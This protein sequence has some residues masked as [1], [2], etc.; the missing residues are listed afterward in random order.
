MVRKLLLFTILFLLLIVVLGGCSEANAPSQ[1]TESTV[2]PIE[3]VGIPPT[4]T[5]EVNVTVSPTEVPDFPCD[6][7][8]QSDR[9]GN[10]EIYVMA[11]DGS[12]Q[13][14]LSQNPGDDFDPVWSPDGT[15]IAFVSNR[16]NGG[17]GGLFVYTMRADGSDVTQVSHMNESR[18]P[19]WSPAGN[20]IVYSSQGDIYV[21]DVI[22]GEEKN[23][24]NSPE[25]DEQPKISPSGRQIAWLIGSESD[26]QLNVMDMDGTNRLKVTHAGKVFD[27]EW[28]VDGRIFTHWEQPEGICNNCLVT[29]DGSQVSD[30]GGKGTIQEFRPFWTADGDRVELISGD[31]HGTG[32]EDV[33]LVGDIFPDIFY[34]LTNS[35]GNDR[36]PD[37][38]RMC[39]PTHG[40]YPQ[41]GADPEEKTVN[42]PVDIGSLVIGYTG[43]IGAIEQNDIDQA[44]AELELE[45]VKGENITEL[46]DKGVDAI[47]IASNR[48]DITGSYPAIHDAAER[49]IPLFILNA[50][51]NEPGVINLSAEHEIY[52]S[53]FNW[54]FQQMNGEGKFIYYNF[55]DNEY[56]QN[57]VDSALVHYPEIIGVKMA[58]DYNGNSFTQQDI[59]GMIISDPELDAVW[60]TEKMNDIFWG[61]ND[62]AAPRRLPAECMARKDELISWKILMDSGSDFQCITHIRPGGTAYEGIYVAFYYLSGLKFKSDAFY[63]NSTNTLHYDIPVITNAELPKWIGPPMDSL[64]EGDYGLLSLPPMTAD[65]IKARWFEE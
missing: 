56:I 48:W 49:G 37:T 10:L 42:I 55:G 31:I 18:F 19:D 54:I 58:A 53:T 16:D 25:W 38:A 50:E 20:Q 63:E 45:C 28:S 17:E 59:T 30:A 24:T 36:N 35:P 6:I 14:N 22:T 52:A 15:Q 41:F 51:S 23:L 60:S 12:N 7:A 34:P 57:E 47:V 33:F 13:V 61:I 3:E 21:L 5:K 9:D 65:E 32:N 62:P 8:F 26:F 1:T 4:E 40:V 29:A 27:A 64:R 43:S 39:G 2:D 44:C 11:P 46:A